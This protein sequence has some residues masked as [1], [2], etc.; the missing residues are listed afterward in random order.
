MHII[1]KLSQAVI[2]LTSLYWMLSRKAANTNF[3]IFGLTRQEFTPR[4]YHNKGKDTNN[5]TTET[6]KNWYR[7]FTQLKHIILNLGQL[8]LRLIHRAQCFLLGRWA[9]N[10]NFIGF[11]FTRPEFEPTIYVYL[12]SR[13]DI[14]CANLHI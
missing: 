9:A 6:I 14:T 3:I 1:M 7:H 13:I 8:V 12:I 2:F 11:C 4:I 10:T 5:Y